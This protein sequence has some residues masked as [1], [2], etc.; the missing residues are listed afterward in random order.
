MDNEL[1][2][3][4]IKNQTHCS[5][6]SYL[7][8]FCLFKDKFVSQFSQ[9]LC[10]LESS[11]MVYICGMSD[12]FVG[13]RLGVMAHILIFYRCFFLSLYCML[14]LKNRQRFFMEY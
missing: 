10:K 2:Y 6:S 1:L 4:G 8:I 5:F 9:E 3:C 13:L 7:A 14:T 11:R 12:C